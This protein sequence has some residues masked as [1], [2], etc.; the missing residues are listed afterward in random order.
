MPGPARMAWW[1]ED[2]VWCCHRVLIVRIIYPGDEG[3]YIHIDALALNLIFKKKREKSHILELTVQNYRHH[4]RLIS[5]TAQIVSAHVRHNTIQSD[6]LP[7]L[8][9]DIYATLLSLEGT[10][11]A[12]SD[13]V[14]AYAH[15]LEHEHAA[16]PAARR[17]PMVADDHLVC[18]EDGLTMKMLKRHLITVH[19]LTPDQYRAKWGLPSDY[20]MVAA[21]Y[22]RLRSSLAKESG[23][24]LRPEARPKRSRS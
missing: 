16:Q 11:T 2:G 21:N 5:L 19:G 20:P 15:T 12:A 23:L 17:A 24:G 6:A 22:A 7:D 9:R 18:L 1:G 14:P 4:D 3:P 13:D 8:I 10:S